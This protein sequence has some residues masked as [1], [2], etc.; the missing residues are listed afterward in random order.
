MEVCSHTPGEFVSNIFTIPKKSGGNRLV[1][2][3]RVLSGFLEHIP[4]RME[5]I[6]LLKFVLKQGDFR[7]KHDSRDTYLTVL[8][9]KNLRICLHLEGRALTDSLASL[10]VFLLQAEF[11]PKQ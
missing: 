8:V 1:V 4:F 2:D 11:S 3:T 10:L 7:R 5:D 6:S 9:D